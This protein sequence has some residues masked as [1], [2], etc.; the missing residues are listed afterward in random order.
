MRNCSAPP[1][2]TPIAS[3][4]AGSLKYFHTAAIENRIIEKFRKTG[5][6][7]GSPNMSKQF[8]IPMAKAAKPMKKRYGKIIRFKATASSQRTL[9]AEEDVKVWLTAGE[10]TIP[11]TVITARTTARVQKSRLAK[12]HTS[13][14]GFSLIHVVKTGMNEAVIDPSPTSRRKR[15]GMRYARTKKSAARE[16][17]S[18]RTIP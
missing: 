9:L 2:K 18:R 17:P 10:K 12:S 8:N 1:T 7:A 15:F 13:S 3:E 4:T 6:E 11:R 14:F 5:V 16:V